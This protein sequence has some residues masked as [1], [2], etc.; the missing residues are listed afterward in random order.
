RVWG[1][2][3]LSRTPMTFS[4]ALYA[5]R[6]NLTATGLVL[7]CVVAL[8]SLAA[9]A[10]VVRPVRAL[11][12]QTKAIAANDP[13]GFRPISRPVVDELAQLSEA[14]AA[15][16]SALR[17]RNDYIRSFAAGV[18]HEFKTPLSSI[19]GAVELLR[20][21]GAMPPEQRERFL[22]NIDLDARRL[23]Q[24]VRRLHDLARADS[25]AGTAELTEVA[26]VLEGLA[27]RAKAGGIRL[28]IRGTAPP[29]RLPAEVLDQVLWQLITNARQHGGEAVQVELLVE[30]AFGGGTARFT[31]KDDGKGISEANR[32][33]LFEA[34]FT[35]AREQ[36]G[37]GLGL[38]IARS[39]LKSVGAQL[40]LLE[41]SGPGVAF[42]VVAPTQRK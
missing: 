11:V 3:V 21:T 1:A 28:S 29:V 13:A 24:L 16:A 25:L 34:F 26:P 36:G 31:V 22:E 18:S 27:Q 7:L 42:A 37:T 39:M 30:A 20:G 15:M 35:T 32:A 9:A 2:V 33:K 14:L 19:Q 38:T 5:D 8:G 23:T 41:A 10:F 4:K 12:R 17:D 40:E 6:W